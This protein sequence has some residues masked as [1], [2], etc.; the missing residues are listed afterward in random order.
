MGMRGCL[1]MVLFVGCT[2]HMYTPAARVVPVTIAD[3]PRP[4]TGDVQIDAAAADQLLESAL[5]GGNVRYRHG[6]RESLALTLDA[7]ALRTVDVS[8]PALERTGG[9]GRV[10]I[11]LHYKETDIDED[12][13]SESAFMLVSGMG[14]GYATG[15]GGWATGDVGVG[16]SGRGKYVR[17]TGL[18]SLY[19]SQPIGSQVIETDEPTRLSRTVGVHFTSGAEL[20][21]Q[22]SA[23]IIGA[24][25]GRL[26]AASN[27]LHESSSEWNLGLLAG[28]RLG[29]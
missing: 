21:P 11:Q 16:W 4:G 12:D 14:G 18:L 9:T 27:D 28:L 8:D 2:R 19:A 10:G 13:R 26:W 15:A 20:G 25:V 29:I 5:V 1:V 22:A 17:P 3:A 7:G 23:F 24:S 6:L